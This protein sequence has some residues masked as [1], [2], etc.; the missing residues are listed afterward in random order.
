[1]CTLERIRLNKLLEKVKEYREI[2]NDCVDE[3]FNNPHFSKMYLDKVV[4]I[5][6]E[7]SELT[8]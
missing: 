2:M 5:E 8:E 3:A 1:M 6:K 4:K 7:L